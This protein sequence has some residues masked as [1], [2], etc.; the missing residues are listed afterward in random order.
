VCMCLVM[1][2]F[3]VNGTRMLLKKSPRTSTDG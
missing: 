1:Q 2:T 3:D